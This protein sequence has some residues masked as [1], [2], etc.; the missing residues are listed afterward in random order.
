[1][2]KL[3]SNKLVIEKHR[4]YLRVTYNGTIL[5]VGMVLCGLVISV[6]MAI[7]IFI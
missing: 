2:K 7:K 3:T 1:M 4:E 6:A 5:I